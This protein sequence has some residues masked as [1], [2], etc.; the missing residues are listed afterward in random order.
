MTSVTLLR[1]VIVSLSPSIVSITISRITKL[2]LQLEVPYTTATGR[3]VI[4]I[5]SSY[6]V[7]HGLSLALAIIETSLYSNANAIQW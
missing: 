7:L 6:D 5:V 4:V 3:L 2:Q 1:H